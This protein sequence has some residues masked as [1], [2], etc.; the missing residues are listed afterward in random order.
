M[1][2]RKR[3]ERLGGTFTADE[4]ASGTKTQGLRRKI[5]EGRKKKESRRREKRPRRRNGRKLRKNRSKL[6]KEKR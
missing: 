3:S 4:C 2:H 5:R 1:S 6:R